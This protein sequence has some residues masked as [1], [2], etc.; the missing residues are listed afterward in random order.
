MRALAQLGRG[1]VIQVV[2]R[3]IFLSGM[4]VS[5]GVRKDDRCH[6]GAIFVVFIDIP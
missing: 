2:V 1:W 3:L 5:D 4:E 6:L